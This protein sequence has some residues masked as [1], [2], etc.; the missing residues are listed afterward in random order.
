MRKLIISRIIIAAVISMLLVAAVLY[1]VQTKQAKETADSTAQ[2]LLDQ[3]EV[4]IGENEA[5][6]A[7]LTKNLKEEYIIRSKAFA[8]MIALDPTILTN[9]QKLLEIQSLLN[10]DELHVSDEKG[11]LLWGTVEGF[12]GFDFASTDQSK[13]FVELLTDKNL[14]IAQDPTPN[15]IAGTLFQYIGVARQDKAGI[16]Q[17]GIQPTRLD[18]AL[19]NTTIDKV[20]SGYTIGTTGYV[21]A[22][23][24]EDGTVVY[25]PD[26]SLIGKTCEEIGVNPADEKGFAT[27]SSS[28]VYY[29]KRQIGEYNVYTAYPVSEMYANRNSALM[30]STVLVL[31]I[32][33]CLMTVISLLLN[34][35][36]IKG[37]NSILVTMKKIED[38]DKEARLEVKTCKEFEQLSNGINDMVDKIDEKMAET[39]QLVGEQSLLLTKVGNA[40]GIINEYSGNMQAISSNIS[41][42]ATSQ[43]QSVTELEEMFNSILRQVKENQ[44][45]AAHASEIAHNSET[46]LEY[47]MDKLSQMNTSMD[48]ISQASQSIGQVIKTVSDIAFQTN[49]LALNAS[50]E[51]AR[52]G[53]H[54]KGFA[55]VATEVRSLATKTAEAAAGTTQLIEDALDTVRK[56][57]EIA[58]ETSEAMNQLLRETKESAALIKEISVATSAQAEAIETISIGVN[59]ISNVIQTNVQVSADA[60]DTA[61]KLSSQALVL[62]KLVANR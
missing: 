25:A 47:G 51:A 19:A 10:V 37:I 29:N 30:I 62:N 50:V 42:G 53:E 52:A 32:F 24:V 4:K 6:I 16:V 55:V 56:G 43:A 21:M 48:E 61:G 5:E 17:V 38:G 31:V 49:I 36:V 2:V 23:N 11:I 41:N 60:E 20:V 45:S 13:V 7:E 39:E 34:R 15:G 14:E 22:I 27:L 3:I 57:Q 9:S 46:H 35:F 59:Q 18:E 1:V 28:E 40:A 26:S 58:S 12:F 44:E 54:G 8:K 33:L